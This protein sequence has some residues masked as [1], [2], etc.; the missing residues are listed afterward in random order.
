[1]KPIYNT[2]EDYPIED[3][4]TYAGIDCL[5][6]SELAVTL[7]GPGRM[8]P[9]YT[10]VNAGRQS[11]EYIPSAFEYYRNWMTPAFDLILDMEMNGM[12]YDVERNRQLNSQMQME[13]LTLEGRIRSITGNKINLNSGGEVGDFLYNVKGYPVLNRT[14]NGDPAT[15]A[16]ALKALIDHTG[17]E[18]LSDLAKFGD[19]SSVWRTFI[20]TYVEDFVKADGRIYPSYN[21]HGT[22]SGRISGDSPNLT[23]LPRAKHGY[24]V[25]EC[26]TVEEGNC[27]ITLDFSSAEVKILGAISKDPLLLKAIAEG[28]DFHS[29]T[30]S[31]I[32]GIPY[33]EYIHVLEDKNN[34]L[35]KKY[36]ELRQGAKAVTFN[37]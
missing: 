3:L 20:R 32:H 7:A 8:K 14:K 21:L 23:Q 6:T 2:Y 18:W 26:Y 36:K 17:E 29:F 5:V 27:F 15:D 35:A 31:T 11:R 22:S 24:N 9:E 34:P 1:M 13:I 25:R 30:A 4:L 19:I 37:R 12:K 33:D 16:D 10:F 28:K